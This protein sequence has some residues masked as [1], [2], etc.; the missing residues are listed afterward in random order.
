MSRNERVA[1]WL[2]ALNPGTALLAVVALSLRI[3]NL[4]AGLRSARADSVLWVILGLIGWA[5]VLNG[6]NVSRGAVN[7]LVPFIFIWLY[8]IGRW[9]VKSPARVLEGFLAGTAFLAVVILVGRMLSLEWTWGGFD[10][11][12]HFSRPTGRGVVLG[13][14]SNG[15]G[16]SLA[17]GVIGGL[18]IS[19][20]AGNTK[21][22][23]KGAIIAALC[24]GAVMV[25][26]SRGAMVGVT[27]GVIAAGVLLSPRVLLL[28]S[29]IGVA[30]SAL[31]PVVAPRIWD[32]IA[33]IVDLVGNQSNVGRLQIW[34]GTLDL[35]RE[36]FW[37]GVGPGN[38]GSVYP[39]FSVPGY[40]HF[41]TPHNNILNFVSGW[42]AIAGFLFFGW[43]AW[44]MVRS[45]VRGLTTHQ[46]IMW[47]ILL[48]F[49]VHVLFDDLMA[50]HIGLFLGC[51]ENHGDNQSIDGHQSIDGQL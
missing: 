13:V 36:H 27:A 44:V 6:Y 41:R 23:V 32:R 35:I 39:A 37:L 22:R 20:S 17:A 47:V 30:A 16:V 43:I 7:W 24:L 10:I 26:L 45:L 38:F 31:A 34:R 50:V 12:A 9:G 51:L 18:G 46:K 19:V 25:T 8:C 28:F 42:G 14:P 48:T 1:A 33:S 15:L 40:E 49:W 4:A 2:V 5:S 3:R 29:A 21:S 11:L